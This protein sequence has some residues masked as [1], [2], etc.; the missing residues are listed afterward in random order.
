MSPTI[1]P[2]RLLTAGVINMG[3]QIDPPR[4][5]DPNL[6]FYYP[7]GYQMEFIL[8]SDD[9][10]QLLLGNNIAIDDSGARP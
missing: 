1:G 10:S 8:T 2:L 6:R 7:F 3:S 5:P 4:Y 9:G